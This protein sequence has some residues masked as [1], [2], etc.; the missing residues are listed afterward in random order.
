M[1]APVH[2]GRIVRDMCLEP[3][4]LSVTAAAAGLG[5]SRQAFNNLVN[6]KA[7][8]SPTMAVRLEKAFGGDAEIWMSL[9]TAYDLAEAYR[10]L[11]GVRVKSFRPSGSAAA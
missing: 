1:K 8:M 5:V 4:S 7:A 10:D 11:R 6:E 9:Q 2:P 3:L